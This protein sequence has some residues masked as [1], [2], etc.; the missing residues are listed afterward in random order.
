MSN[1][2]NCVCVHACMHIC[3]WPLCHVLEYSYIILVE[4]VLVLNKAEA[5]ADEVYNVLT[6]H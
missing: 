4:Q 2:S 3:I 5:E 1:V 6:V